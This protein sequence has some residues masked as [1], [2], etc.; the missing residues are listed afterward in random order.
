MISGV[1]L[2]FTQPLDFAI[3]NED[4]R[5][6]TFKENNNKDILQIN[7]K[8]FYLV[9]K[10]ERIC[11]IMINHPSCSRQHAVIQ[12]RKINKKNDTGNIENY[13]K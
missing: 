5:L 7:K 9:G 13:V 1:V 12:F 2:K 6:Y 4:W 8:S 11:H 10:D 3:P